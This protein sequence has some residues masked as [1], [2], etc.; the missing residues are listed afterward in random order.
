MAELINT[1]KRESVPWVSEIRQGMQKDFMRKCNEEGIL[2][3]IKCRG[4]SAENLIKVIKNVRNTIA[5]GSG[6]SSRFERLMQ[7]SQ[8][9]MQY[10]EPAK[11][12]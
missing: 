10:V 3:D 6:P 8:V 1:P 7:V 11:S 4:I 9:V 12:G 5:P 2:M